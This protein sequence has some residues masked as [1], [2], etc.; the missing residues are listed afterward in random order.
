MPIQAVLDLK[1]TTGTRISSLSYTGLTL[2]YY[3]SRIAKWEE[4]SGVHG[5]EHRQGHHRRWGKPEIGST[6]LGKD[7]AVYHELREARER[8]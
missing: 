8:I 2:P 6:H 1:A 4:E 3:N 5:K 7:A